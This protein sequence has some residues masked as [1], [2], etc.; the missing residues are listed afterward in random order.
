MYKIG[1]KTFFNRETIIYPFVCTETCAKGSKKG[2]I[3]ISNEQYSDILAYVE[4]IGYAKVWIDF[5]NL[6]DLSFRVIMWFDSDILCFV[7]ME[8]WHALVLFAR[9]CFQIPVYII[10]E[11]LPSVKHESD[12]LKSE[13]LDLIFCTQV[14]CRKSWGNPLW[15]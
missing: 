3:T 5:V 8:F 2:S 9:D 14:L 15:R 12:F 4:K 7:W 10:Q 13:V 11:T 6:L 1:K